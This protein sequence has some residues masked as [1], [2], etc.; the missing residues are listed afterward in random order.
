MNLMSTSEEDF[1]RAT[2]SV[3]KLCVYMCVK[4]GWLVYG[5]STLGLYK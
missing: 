1:V 3:S 4:V 5:M 2:A